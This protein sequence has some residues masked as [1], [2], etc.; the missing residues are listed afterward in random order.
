MRWDKTGRDE[1]ARLIST[2]EIDPNNSNA[3][4]LGDIVSGHF[5]PQ[6][7]QPPPSG[8]DSAIRRFRKIFRRI[9]AD[10]ELRGARLVS[11]I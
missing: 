4:Y 1:L 11:K 2:G 3:D 10:R 9:Q 7:Q 6:Y 8:R 5:F